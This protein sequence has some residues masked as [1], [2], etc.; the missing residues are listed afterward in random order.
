MNKYTHIRTYKH[1]NWSNNLPQWTKQHS[2]MKVSIYWCCEKPTEVKRKTLQHQK[3]GRWPR[4]PKGNVNQNTKTKFNLALK[5]C[6]I[7]K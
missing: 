7:L 5:K 2:K 4:V 1:I 3:V 6:R